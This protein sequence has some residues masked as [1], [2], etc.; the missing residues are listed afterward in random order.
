MPSPPTAKRGPAA[1]C[2]RRSNPTPRRTSPLLKAD[3]H[4]H[5]YFSR[6]ALTSPEKY[7][8]ACQKRGINCVAVTEHNNIAGALAVEKI[9]PFTGIIREGALGPTRPQVD[10]IEVF[11]ARIT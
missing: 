1:Q 5:T 3:L 9:A 4:T 6:D 8:Q 10:A 11:N 2:A 7:V